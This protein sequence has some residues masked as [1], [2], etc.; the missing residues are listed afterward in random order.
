LIIGFI[1]LRKHNLQSVFRIKV[2]QSIGAASNNSVVYLAEHT[3][4]VPGT[5]ESAKQWFTAALLDACN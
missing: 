5:E 4:A 1:P 2:A 3:N